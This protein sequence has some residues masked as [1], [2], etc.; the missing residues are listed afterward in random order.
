V[1][2]CLWK[3]TQSQVCRWKES[4][5]RTS[6]LDRLRPY[7]L[8]DRDRDDLQVEIRS[9]IDRSTNVCQVSKGLKLK[10]MI[11]KVRRECKAFE[12]IVKADVDNY[13]EVY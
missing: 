1:L 12:V 3:R 8:W 6:E 2:P 13:F 11:L 7:S 9:L 10:S 4:W 5:G